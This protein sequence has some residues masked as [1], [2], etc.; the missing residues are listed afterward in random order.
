MTILFSLDNKRSKNY[1]RAS[2]LKAIHQVAFQDA[3]LIDLIS[4]LTISLIMIII[5]VVDPSSRLANINIT[6]RLLLIISLA[7]FVH[8]FIKLIYRPNKTYKAICSELQ[9]PIM[10]NSVELSEEHSSSGCPG[11]SINYSIVTPNSKKMG[12]L[13]KKNDEFYLISL[14]DTPENSYR[15]K[16]I[17]NGEEIRDACIS[18]NLFGVKNI[19][20]V[21]ARLK[22]DEEYEPYTCINPMLIDDSIVV[23]DQLQLKQ[24][25]SI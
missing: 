16:I 10:V 21:I 5:N 2:R 25:I 23:Y 7:M 14:I 8:S 4:V 3:W 18:A 20:I 1:D 11:L 15:L 13:I 9:F 19:E 12:L 22:S 17:L 6:M 24:E